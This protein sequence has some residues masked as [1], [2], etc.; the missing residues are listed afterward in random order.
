VSAMLEQLPKRL[1]Q[2]PVVRGYP[3]PWFVAWLPDATGQ[4]V[5]DFRV[6]DA[7]KVR[8]AHQEHRCFICGGRLPAVAAFT[9]GPMCAVNRVSAE[10]PAHRECSEWSARI[11]PFLSRPDMRRRDHD[12]PEG[13]SA[14][15]G[16]M[17]TRNPGVTLVWTSSTYKRTPVGNSHLWNIGTPVSVRAFREGRPATQEE[18]M[19]SIASGLPKLAEAAADDGHAGMRMLSQMVVQ[20]CQVLNLNSGE[21]LEMAQVQVLA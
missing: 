14:P 9:I 11:C 12:Y 2:L 4:Q 17:L 6:V 13:H 20:A 10:P 21:L 19:A 8:R 5:P 18:L 15:A 3:V 7:R 16:E 1:A